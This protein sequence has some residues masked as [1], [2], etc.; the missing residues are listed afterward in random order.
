MAAIYQWFIGDITYE[1]YTTTL[2]PLEATEGLTF[3]IDID[4]GEMHEISSDSMD[5]TMSLV[6]MVKVDGLL[7]APEQ[8]DELDQVM[9]VVSIDKYIGLLLAPEQN[10][11]LDQVMTLLSM[12]LDQKLITAYS[13]DEGIELDIDL[14]SSNCSMDAV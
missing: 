3:T 5:Q 11:Q 1:L 7:L 14:D 8:D 2:Y 12:T 6:S 10:D 4:L 13:P 9:T